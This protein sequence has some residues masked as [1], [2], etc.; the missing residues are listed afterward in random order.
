ME[1]FKMHACLKSNEEIVFSSSR[2]RAADV[3][4]GAFR[5]LRYRLG[6]LMEQRRV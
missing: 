5:N 3:D 1:K 6:V 2:A 4:R